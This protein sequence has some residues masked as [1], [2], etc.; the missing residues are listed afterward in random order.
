MI[1]HQHPDQSK[2]WYQVPEHRFH[3]AMHVGDDLVL[4]DFLARDPKTLA[5]RRFKRY[6]QDN[7]SQQRECYE[8]FG[9]RI[10]TDD[11]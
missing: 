3:L 11:Y 4:Y 10:K 7:F 9:E 2:K 5:I 6:L 8:Q 1:R